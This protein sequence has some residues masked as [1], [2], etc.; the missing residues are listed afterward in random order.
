MT[1]YCKCGGV[2][3]T[4]SKAGLCNRCTKYNTSLQNHK[5]Y[6]VRAAKRKAERSP[7]EYAQM[8]FKTPE[9]RREQCRDAMRKFRYLNSVKPSLRA[10][11][12]KTLRGVG[13]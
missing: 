8:E 3:D 4:N 13:E 6:V 1:K 7:R 9:T 12:A 2:V 10:R 5:Y 11:V